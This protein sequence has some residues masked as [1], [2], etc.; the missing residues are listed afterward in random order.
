VRTIFNIDMRYFDKACALIT[1]AVILAFALLMAII[2]L[3]L[4]LGGRFCS[5]LVAHLLDAV[6]DD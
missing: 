6:G 1:G 3:P 5:L 2:S 4:E